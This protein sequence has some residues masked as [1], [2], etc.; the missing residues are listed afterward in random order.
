MRVV[1]VR[2]RIS[3]ERIERKLLEKRKVIA[4]VSD[5]RDLRSDLVKKA[6]VV[7][8]DESSKDDESHTSNL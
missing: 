1:R 5:L 8:V 4:V 2:D 6:N 7:I 3:R